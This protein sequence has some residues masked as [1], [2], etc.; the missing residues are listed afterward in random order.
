MG[1][2]GLPFLLVSADGD[3]PSLV[4]RMRKIA[5]RPVELVASRADAERV[6][7]ARS[8]WA[9]LVLELGDTPD[10]AVAFAEEARRNAPHMPMLLLTS[11]PERDLLNRVAQLGLATLAWSPPPDELLVTFLRRALEH[12][13]LTITVGL[14]P[15]LRLALDAEILA[16]STP[17]EALRASELLRLVVAGHSRQEVEARMQIG[18][19]CYAYHVGQLLRATGAADL[20]AL[21]IRIMRRALQMK[22]S[23]AAE[24]AAHVTE[25][26][27]LSGVRDRRTGRLVEGSNVKRSRPAGG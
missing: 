17:I 11:S 12:R 13:E 23:P 10:R 25:P 4:R 19:D 2:D 24:D 9:A 7:G 27:E 26:H 15:R 16:S 20:Q 6:W 18:S 22:R 14:D 21:V 3:A 8:E 5:R 1:Y